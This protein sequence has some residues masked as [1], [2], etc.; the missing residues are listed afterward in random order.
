M[1]ETSVFERSGV[2]KLF[3][4]KCIYIKIKIKGE[5]AQQ[6]YAQS[7]RRMCCISD[8]MFME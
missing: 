6:L 3:A 1:F 4:I 7:M 8:Q 5:Q 2:H